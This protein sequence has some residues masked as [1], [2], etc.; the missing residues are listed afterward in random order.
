MAA[1]RL[2]FKQFVQRG[3]TLLLCGLYSSQTTPSD[4]HDL[5]AAMG[6]PWQRVN[7]HR[8][9]FAVAPAAVASAGL[10]AGLLPQEVCAKA[11]TLEGVTPEAALYVTAQGA[12][13][14]GIGAAVWGAQPVPTGEAAVALQ[15]VGEGYFGF[16][17]DVN[18]EL[19]TGL[20]VL[21]V[22]LA[23]A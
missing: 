18:G 2:P 3:G 7:Y 11:V 21:G 12:T 4:M 14:E 16:V 23:R 1:G 9:T 20:I 5:F 13:L 19:G 22:C 15:R 6:V 8:T 17:G 10:D